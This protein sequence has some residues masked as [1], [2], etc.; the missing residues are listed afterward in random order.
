VARLSETQGT[1]EQGRCG[2]ALLNP[3]DKKEWDRPVDSRMGG[4]PL[5]SYLRICSSICAAAS[6]NRGSRMNTICMS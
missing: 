5:A 4:W 3:Q 2:G 6:I 1:R